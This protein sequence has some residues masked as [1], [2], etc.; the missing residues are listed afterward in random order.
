MKMNRP[1][2]NWMHDVSMDSMP[3]THYSTQQAEIE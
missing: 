2:R 3:K 1:V